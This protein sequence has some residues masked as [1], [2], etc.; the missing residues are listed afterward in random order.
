MYMMAHCCLDSAFTIGNEAKVVSTIS[1]EI[2]G[3][4]GI[5]LEKNIAFI[6]QFLSK[7]KARLTKRGLTLK[8]K[9]R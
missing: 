6:G 5:Q 8:R 4:H 7:G 3:A 2:M 1:A 9:I